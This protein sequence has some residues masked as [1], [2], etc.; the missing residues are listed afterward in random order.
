M[1]FF[2]IVENRKVKYYL[3]K[4]Q[5]N[6]AL[7]HTVTAIYTARVKVRGPVTSDTWRFIILAELHTSV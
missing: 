4:V 1:G 5:K 6:I 7:T 2:L 3:K